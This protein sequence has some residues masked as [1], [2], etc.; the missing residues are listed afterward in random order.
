VLSQVSA[1]LGRTVSFVGTTQAASIETLASNGL[2]PQDMENVKAVKE[3]YEPEVMSQPGVIG[4]GVGIGKPGE[5]TIMVF[6]DRTTGRSHAIPDHLDK[7]KVQ[8]MPTDPF[9][10]R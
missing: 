4:M 3:R 1:R 10:A 7:V 9:M 8:V 6:V 5:A 2:L